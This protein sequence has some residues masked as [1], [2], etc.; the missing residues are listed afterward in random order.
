M[1]NPRDTVKFN[2]IGYDAQTFYIDNSTITYDQNEENGSA[3][4]GLAVT[5]SADATVA[6]ADDG[7]AIVGKLVHVE[8]DGKAAVQTGGYVGL[9]GGD[10]ATLTLGSKIVGDQGA[11]AALGYVRSVATATA[12]ELGVARGMIVDA[13][14][15]TAVWVRL[16]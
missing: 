4:A 10:A 6:L 3:Q 15:P 1:A 2:G 12:A 13:A 7:D 5:L 9:P 11:G 8:S 16:E 14:D